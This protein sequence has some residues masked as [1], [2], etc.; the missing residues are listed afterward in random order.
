MKKLLPLLVVGIF[1]LSGLGAVAVQDKK[2]IVNKP[3]TTLDHE[4]EV[5]IEGGLF[6]KQIATKLL[7]PGYNVKVVNTGEET[8]NGSLNLTITT[9]AWFMLK[10][11]FLEL[12]NESFSL[13]RG[14]DKELVMGPVFGFGPAEMNVSLNGIITYPRVHDFHWEESINT[15]FVLLSFVRMSHYRFSI[16]G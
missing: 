4:I 13:L 5:L 16:G 15:G 1:V 14:T 11:G 12:E 8:V 3:L 10:G 9:D 7:T 2:Q 6:G